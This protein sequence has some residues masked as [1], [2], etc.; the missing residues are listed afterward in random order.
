MVI[1]AVDGSDST[2]YYRDSVLTY[3]TLTEGNVWTVSTNGAN[4]AFSTD[5]AEGV[6]STE[7]GATAY[8]AADAFSAA[9]YTK[10]AFTFGE[11]NHIRDAEYVKPSITSG[12]TYPLPFKITALITGALGSGTCQSPEYKKSEDGEVIRQRMEVLIS[13]DKETWTLVDTIST[14]TDKMAEIKSVICEGT[15]D[16]YVRLQAIM[17]VGSSSS[18]DRKINLNDLYIF[19]NNE[20][21]G[22]EDIAVEVVKNDAVFD[23]QGRQVSKMVPGQLYIQNGKKVVVR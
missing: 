4:I 13:M 2:A 23:L 10:N 11:I 7:G 17:P 19:S 22:I 8:G 21:L 1:Q 18:S 12:Q 20:T 16:V 6:V 15:G 5:G 3:S 14:T 9:L